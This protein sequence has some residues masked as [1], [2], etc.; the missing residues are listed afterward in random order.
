MHD[1]LCVCPPRLALAVHRY[2]ILLACMW[3]RAREWWAYAWP[4]AWRPNAFIC[5]ACLTVRLIMPARAFGTVPLCDCA[6][7]CMRRYT[8]VPL[9][10]PWRLV[11]SWWVPCMGS[12]CTMAGAVPPSCEPCLLCCVTCVATVPSG[13][14]LLGSSCASCSCVTVKQDIIAIQSVIIRNNL[15]EENTFTY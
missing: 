5:G 11:S 2:L 8:R 10:W 14:Y 12:L 15:K 1:D 7:A 13:S 6:R 4:P 9:P 3:S